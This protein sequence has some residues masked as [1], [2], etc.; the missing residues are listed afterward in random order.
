MRISREIGWKTAAMI[1]DGVGIP[2]SNRTYVL[3]IVREY[4]ET[5]LNEVNDGGRWYNF[6]Q[7]L[8]LGALLW[9][10][11]GAVAND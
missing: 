1:R 2:L 6:L 7:Y 3:F 4:D 8:R 10:S 9:I 5:D 11:P